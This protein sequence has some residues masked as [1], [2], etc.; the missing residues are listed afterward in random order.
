MDLKKIKLFQ[1]LSVR[2]Y[3]TSVALGAQINSSDKTVRK[4]LKELNEILVLNGA[5][6]ETK[7]G[8]GYKLCITNEKD[9][10]YF[11]D[12]NIGTEAGIPNS[13]EERIYFLERYLLHYPRYCKINDLGEMLYVSHRTITKDLKII[14]ENLKK[15]NIH[16][17]RRPNYGIRIEG[18]EFDIR[19]YYVNLSTESIGLPKLDN[20]RD[21]LVEAIMICVQSVLEQQGYQISDV[22]LNSLV[23]HLFVAIERIKTGNE[24]VLKEE[25]MDFVLIEDELLVVNEILQ[26]LERMMNEKLEAIKFPKSEIKYIAIHLAGKKITHKDNAKKN[27]VITKKIDLIVTEMLE[28]IYESFKVDLRDNFALRMSLSEH[29]VP[30]EIRLRF[31]MTMKNP[32]LDEIKRK[33]LFAFA[34]A[35]YACGIIGR[36]YGK[37][38]TEDEVGY[39]TLHFEL[40]LN[41]DSKHITKK[42]ILILCSSGKGSARFLQHRY[43]EKFKDYIDKIEVFESHHLNSANLEH[44]DYIFTTVPIK[45]QVPVPILEVSYFLEENDEKNVLY[46]LKKNVHSG[47]AKYYQ[48][49]LFIPNLEA[50]TKTEVLDYL[51]DYIERIADVPPNFREAVYERERTAPTA[52]GNLVALPH[53]SKTLSNKTFAC[54][55]ILNKPILWDE[56]L[57]QVVFLV[58]IE[59]RP[60]KE[61]QTFYRTTSRLLI[62]KQHIDELIQTRNFDTLLR[63]LKLVEG[64][65]SYE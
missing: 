56:Q 18:D 36:Q 59:N 46:A 47:I 21:E 38:L 43:Y 14:E 24:I 7:R 64:E 30:L 16:L 25:H 50:T 17:E 51:C 28:K 37:V 10:S 65:E 53:P 27:V 2:E 19:R 3:Q 63:L 61:I 49:K 12:V 44:I 58:S 48:A 35:T 33:F 8:H 6:I 29:I 42:N 52:F 41:Q 31:D 39:F 40:A 34:I 22:S 9:F 4:M 13:S 54:V 55:A 26:T 45:E 60:S 62:S 11:R 5:Y 15:F 32:L 57:V 1:L 23:L 20:N